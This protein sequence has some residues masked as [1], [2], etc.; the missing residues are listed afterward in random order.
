MNVNSAS[1]PHLAAVTHPVPQNTLQ[2]RM[3]T[4]I[5]EATTRLWKCTQTCTNVV[6]A[7]LGCSSEPNAVTLVKTAVD[8]IFCHCSEH[9]LKLPEICVLLNDLPD[10]DFN[11][12]VKSLAAFQQ[13][14]QSFG[15]I[16]T[17]IVPGSFYKRLFTSNSL[18]LVL[19]SNSVNW[20]SEV[21]DELKK[22]RIPMHDEDEGLRIARR[23]LVVQAFAR[24]FRKDF[25]LFLNM[26]AQELV[27]TGHMVISLAGRRS[28]DYHSIQPWDVP[29]I[30]LNDMASRGVISREMF[31]SFYIPLYGPSD[32]E[33][34]EIIE[35]EGSFKINNMYMLERGA[36]KSLVTPKASALTVR[37]TMEPTIVQHFGHSGDVMDEFV[38]T[39]E[40]HI[41][42]SGDL[43]DSLVFLCVSLTKNA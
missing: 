22:N 2:N 36:E 1:T 17:G 27:C 32:K 11:N 37:A 30:P 34:T 31:D 25:T 20:L 42:L 5:E 24:Q 3:K 26:R 29:T 9:R 7:D 15:P 28:S 12:V 10:N 13:N 33:L 35:D 23:P 4:F 40:Q 16:F 14:T 19:S 41:S 21:P 38:R 43:I 8:A 18:H 39:I 6:I